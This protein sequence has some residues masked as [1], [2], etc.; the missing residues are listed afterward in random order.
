MRKPLFVPETKP[1]MQMLDDF[2]RGK[3]HMAFV[4]DEFGT[5]DGL[6][7]VE[8]VLEQI[9]G[10]IEDEHDEKIERP[11]PESAEV[12]LDGAAKIRDV[13]MDYGITM[14]SSAEF[15][16]LAGFLLFRLGTIPRAGDTVEYEGRRYTVLAMDRNRIARV[17]IEKLSATQP[18]AGPPAGS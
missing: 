15:E 7:T 9:V 2:K 3:S 5:I 12:E 8:D 4:V 10:D 6:L 16:T 14:P 17:R 18:K 1:L 13:E 11:V